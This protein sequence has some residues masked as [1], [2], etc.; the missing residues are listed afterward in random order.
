M[1]PSSRK[2]NSRSASQQITRLLRNPKKVHYDVH[3]SPPL[4]ISQKV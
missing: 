2:T 3:K 1:K 4:D